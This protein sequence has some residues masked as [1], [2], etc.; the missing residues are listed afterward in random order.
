MYIRVDESYGSI[1]FTILVDSIKCYAN[2]NGRKYK[3]LSYELQEA[4]DIEQLTAELLVYISQGYILVMKGMDKIYG[5]LLEILNMRYKTENQKPKSKLI[6]DDRE[7]VA[8][9]HEQF[10]IIII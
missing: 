10:R 8:Y 9:I 5:V 6:I 4:E 2:K 3:Y 7:K 1:L